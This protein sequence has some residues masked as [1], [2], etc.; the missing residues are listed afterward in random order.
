MQKL[1]NTQELK[2]ADAFLFGIK[3]SLRDF[4]TD[5]CADS[6]AALTHYAFLSIFPALLVL[7]SLLN[8]FGQGPLLVQELTLSLSQIAPESVVEVL[9]SP[10]ESIFNLKAPI[11]TLI[12]SSLVSFWVASNYIGAFSRAMNRIYGIREKRSFLKK[13]ASHLLLTGSILLLTALILV[14]FTL[15]KPVVNFLSNEVT[16]INFTEDSLSLT[17]LIFIR[18]PLLLLTFILIASLLYY[19][20]PTSKLI[21]YRF[22]TSGTFLAVTVW[23]LISFS[24]GF[25]VKNF[26]SYDNTYGT[27]A[28]VAIF[29]LW[30]WFTNIAL[31][32]GAEL[33]SE[34][35]R[36]RQLS[37]GLPSEK[38]LTLTYRESKN[39]Q[40]PEVKALPVKDGTGGFKKEL[41]ELKTYIFNFFKW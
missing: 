8:I 20:A 34:I 38:K 12:I 22:F 9:R 5:Q 4:F 31:L 17:I 10:L 39:V 19:Y 29:L 21:K 28:G 40:E 2:F 26:S 23:G 14:S 18:W 13:R 7:T 24:F 36:A 27:L 11:I 25:Y 32:L 6:A 37:Q 35:L 3:H 30:I 16:F 15:T 1:P 33:D 41:L